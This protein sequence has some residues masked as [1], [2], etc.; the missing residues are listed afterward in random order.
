[1]RSRDPLVREQA[2]D[3]RET[4]TARVLES[5]P[6][7]DASRKDWPPTSRTSPR[8]TACGLSVLL[9][10]ALEVLDGDEPLPPGCLD[11]LDQRDYATVDRRDAHPE[12]V[13]GL[14]ARVRETLDL[15]ALSESREGD[16]F[17]ELVLVGRA[18]LLG[19]SNTGLVKRALRE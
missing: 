14:A 7:D 5:D 15:F 6:F 4:E 3:V 10:E 19:S 18:R 11:R 9:Q 1:V 8:S 17:G 13:R 12:H 2:R 16:G